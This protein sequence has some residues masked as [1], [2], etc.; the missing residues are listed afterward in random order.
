M[1]TATFLDGTADD[2]LTGTTG[3]VTTLGGDDTPPDE[4]Q[5]SERESEG[6]AETLADKRLRH[7]FIDEAAD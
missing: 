6:T 7:Y 2:D 1:S 5:G 3:E 4:P